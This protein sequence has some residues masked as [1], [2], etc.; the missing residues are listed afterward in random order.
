[1]VQ[2]S[3]TAVSDLLLMGEESVQEAP[4]LLDVDALGSGLAM[5][6]RIHLKTRHLGP[7]CLHLSET[8]FKIFLKKNKAKCTFIQQP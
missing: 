2:R 8:I 4:R 5:E 3:C 7:K 1:M 6:P